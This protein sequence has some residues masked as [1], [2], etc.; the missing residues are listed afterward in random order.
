M[1]ELVTLGENLIGTAI[2]AGAAQLAP[3]FWGEIFSMAG[4]LAILVGAILFIV[5]TF[6]E[7]L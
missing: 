3:Y 2:D 6:K 1:D 7:F 5:W 4:F